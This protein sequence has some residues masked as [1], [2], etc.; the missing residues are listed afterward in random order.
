VYVCMCVEREYVYVRARASDKEKERRVFTNGTCAHPSSAK[1]SVRERK[2]ACVHVER[3]RG[4][5]RECVCVYMCR[6]RERER[7]RMCVRVRV[8]RRGREEGPPMGRAR[9][10]GQRATLVSVGCGLRASWRRDCP[11]FV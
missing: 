6:D 1:E 5:E 8:T 7:E 9:D 3:E 11:I 2:C 4:S 10:P